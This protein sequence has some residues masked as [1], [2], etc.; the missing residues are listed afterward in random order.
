MGCPDFDEE[1]DANQK[2]W[3]WLAD[4]GEIG[5]FDDDHNEGEGK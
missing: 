3:E 4:G 1:Q 2:T 5:D